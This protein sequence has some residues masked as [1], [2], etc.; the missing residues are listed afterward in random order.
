MILKLFVIF[1][2][3][4]WWK[5]ALVTW[6]GFILTTLGIGATIFFTGG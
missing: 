1:S 5:R 6:L 4:P 3:M 2:T